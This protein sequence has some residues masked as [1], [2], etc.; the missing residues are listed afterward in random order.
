MDYQTKQRVIGGLMDGSVG[1]AYGE[2]PDVDRDTFLTPL[3]GARVSANELENRLRN[4]A[5]R[6]C[7][8]PPPSVGN[9]LTQGKIASVP[10]GIFEDIT[11]IGVHT[12]S[13]LATAHEL[14][15]RIENQLP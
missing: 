3:R 1:T 12:S 11:E 7:G 6:L 14:I 5:D 8:P 9:T 10:N 15:S 2:S 4:L 13:A